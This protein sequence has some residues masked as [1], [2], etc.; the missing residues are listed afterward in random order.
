MSHHTLYQMSRVTL[1]DPLAS[2]R[3]ACPFCGQSRSAQDWLR[4]GFECNCASGEDPACVLQ[5]FRV[6]PDG[7]LVREPVAEFWNLYEAAQRAGQQTPRNCRTRT[8]AR[9]SD[10]I[11]WLHRTAA[12]VGG[13]LRPAWLRMQPQG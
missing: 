1:S 9:W 13:A 12:S 4:A 11:E 3:L 8:V 6:E 7:R 2:R 5:T 10:L